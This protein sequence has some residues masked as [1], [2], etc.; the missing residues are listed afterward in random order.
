INIGLGVGYI[1][2]GT[3]LSDVRRIYNGFLDSQLRKSTALSAEANAYAGQA[4]KTDK[5][6][7]DSTT[8]VAAQLADFFT[9]MQA[10]ATS[11]TQSSERS[12]FLTQATALSARFNSVASQLSSQNDNVNAQLNT[13][14]TQVNDLTTT[15]A[16]LNKQI[17]QA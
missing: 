17:T 16:S 8:G 4:G 9:K 6:L 12:S 14:A 15:I 2:A 7:S 11:S 10:I 3:T 13:F 1:G 5:L